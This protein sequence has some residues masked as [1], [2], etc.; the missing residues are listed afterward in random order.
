MQILAF[1]EAA[2][3][4]EL[5]TQVRELQEAAWP[6]ESPAPVPDDAP[7][8]DPALRPLSML[9]VDGGTVL[10]ALDLLTKE[11]GHAGQR[12]AA[13]GLSTVV[14][15][16]EARGRGHGRSLVAKARETLAAQG[17]DLG[18]FT[19]DRPLRTFYESAGWHH[20]PGTVLVGGTPEAPFPSDSP[21]F[22]K[23]TMAAFFS[24]RA[25]RAR[26]SFQGSRIALHP[27]DID[28]LW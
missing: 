6:S 17:H 14:T 1:P 10:A 19:C 2:T 12:Y 9:L 22:D 13:G 27:G 18:L 26:A 23:V 28:K 21:G 4:T 16:R 8:H 11:V 5:R 24:D 7:V 15:R 3:P 25:R 20:L